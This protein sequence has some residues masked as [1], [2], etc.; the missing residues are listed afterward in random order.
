MLRRGTAIWGRASGIVFAESG[1]NMAAAG[2]FPG[3]AAEARQECR[4]NKISDFFC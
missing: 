4:T 1:G 3:P 2:D